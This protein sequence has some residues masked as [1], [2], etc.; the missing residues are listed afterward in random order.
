MPTSLQSLFNLEGRQAVVTGGTSGIGMMIATGLLSAGA[1][2]LITGRDEAKGK[3]IATDLSG[4]GACDFLAA[5]LSGDKGVDTLSARLNDLAPRLSILVNNAGIS[6][7]A[8]PSIDLMSQ[9]NQVLHL[10]LKTPFMLSRLL[11]PLLKSNASPEAPAHIINI[12]S[13]AARVATAMG[14]H[15]YCA[16]K[17]GIDHLTRTLA[18]ELSPDHVLVNAIAPGT[19]PSAMS[20]WMLE[21]E[22]ISRQLLAQIP[23]KR[24]GKTEDIAAL[25]VMIASNAYL[26]G[27]I[28]PIDGGLSLR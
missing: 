10:N 17:A 13:I 21:D 12:G 8:L 23:V 19:F 28:I 26:T 22:T 20:A 24:F 6:E 16:S 11:S 7:T 2:V 5:D 15:A 27:T 3:K 9:W 4:Y 18:Q 1:S 14:A 25:A